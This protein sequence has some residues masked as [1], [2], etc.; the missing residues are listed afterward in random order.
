[1]IETNIKELKCLINLIKAEWFKLL[2]S[3]PF[4]ILCLCNA[5]SL[6]TTVM[7]NFL[8]SKGST[9]YDAVLI[10]LG[11]ILHH[12]I[13]GYVFAAFFLCDEFSYHTFGMSLSCGVSRR[14]I[15][16]AKVFTFLVG[17]LL[18]FLIYTGSVMSVATILNGFGKE[19]SIDIIFLLLCGL[20]GE[21]AM[22]T[23]M[24]LIAVIVKKASI[25]IGLGIGVTYSLIL[26]RTYYLQK[27]IFPFVKYTYS[28]QIEQL[29][30]WGED[31]LLEVFLAVMLL[32]VVIMLI[33]ARF[34]FERAELK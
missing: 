5:A 25:T 8:G 26:G 15:F 7:L 30:F 1:M 6:V 16:D 4:R 14:K 3:F 28:F 19:L 31:F 17:L 23:V 29:I 13:I 11:Y 12:S 24:I 18:L 10:S 32:T 33:V 27:N 2:K 34:I 21:I 9:G 22:G 20:L